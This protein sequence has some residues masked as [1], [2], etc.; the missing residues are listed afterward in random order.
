[1]FRPPK[2]HLQEDIRNILGSIQIMC[3]REILLL[4]GICYKS[5]LYIQLVSRL[6]LKIKITKLKLRLVKAVIKSFRF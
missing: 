3:G 2:C 4:T 1:M 6:K 5:G